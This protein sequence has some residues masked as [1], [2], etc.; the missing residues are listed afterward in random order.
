M[1]ADPLVIAEREFGSRLIGGTGKFASSGAMAA[2]LRASGTQLVTV[3][4]RRVDLDASE[5][6]DIL[7][8]IDRTRMLVMPNTSGALDAQDAV[9]LARLARAAEVADE[10][11]RTWIKLEVTP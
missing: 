5:G 4:L 3:A 8:A 9:R 2:A 1:D 7:D 10:R 11:G 6:E